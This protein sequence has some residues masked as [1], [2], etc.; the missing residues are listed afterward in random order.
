[1]PNLPRHLPLALV[2][3]LSALLPACGETAANAQA[4]GATPPPPEVAVVTVAAQDAPV[5][6]ELPGRIEATRVAQVRARVPGIVQKRFFEEGSEVKAGQ[7]LYQVDPAQY[8][9][10]LASAEAS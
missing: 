4:P 8:E 9:A 7:V 5:Y 6:N 2:L 10:N 3:I 1:M